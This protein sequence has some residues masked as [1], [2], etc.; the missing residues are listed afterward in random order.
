MSTDRREHHAWLHHHIWQG[1]PHLGHHA[2]LTLR[3]R[4]RAHTAVLDR[5]PR[6]SRHPLLGYL[7]AVLAQLAAVGLTLH[8]ANVV[9]TFWFRDALSFLAVAVVALRWGVGPGL[10]STLMGSALLNDLVLPPSTA[11]SRA[12]PGMVKT[13]L[14][15]S[16]S[17]LAGRAVRYAQTY[18]S[19]REQR[20]KVETAVRMRDDILNLATHDLRA[21]ATSVQ[22]RDSCPDCGHP[23]ALLPLGMRYDRLH[24]VQ[25]DALLEVEDT[26]GPAACAEQDLSYAATGPCSVVETR[27]RARARTGRRRRRSPRPPNG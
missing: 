27:A 13:L 15:L 26:A 24:C 1:S 6:L 18:A 8:L 11:W 19:E 23:A 4:V 3:Q 22:T 12:A 7:V 17:V 2:W 25:C 16:V 5:L 9:P 20:G 10:L 21:P 14:F